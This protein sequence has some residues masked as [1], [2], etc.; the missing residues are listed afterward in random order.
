MSLHTELV[1]KEDGWSLYGFDRPVRAAGVPAAARRQRV[2]AQARARPA[3]GARARSGRC[4]ASCARDLAALSSVSGVGRKKAERLVLELQD[5]FGDVLARVP[6]RRAPAGA[7][8][9]VRALIGL[10]YGPGAADD[11]V[12]AALADGAPPRTPRNSSGGRS[13]SSPPPGEGDDRDERARRDRRM[14]LHPLRHHQ[15]QAGA[16]RQR[17]ASADRC[18]HCRA[19]HIVEPDARPVRWNARLDDDR[20]TWSSPIDQHDMTA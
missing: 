4:G 9:A 20:E 15:P 17:P 6:R 12:R 19:W 14:E 8:E 16:R 7:D 3:L 5:K 11:A 13:S 2:R 18:T 10:G 1:V